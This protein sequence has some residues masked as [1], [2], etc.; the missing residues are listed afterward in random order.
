MAYTLSNKCAKNICKR[1]IL[2][3]L[4]IKNVVTFFWNTVY[5]R[6]HTI[7]ACDGKA[8]ILPRHSPR[9]A[10]ASRSKKG[11]TVLHVVLTAQPVWRGLSC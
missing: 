1:T 8:D 6:L 5:N 2:L 10:Y 7:S 4:I 11:A 9:Y 3:Q